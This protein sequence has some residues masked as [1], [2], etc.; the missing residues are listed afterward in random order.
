M[1]RRIVPALVALSLALVACPSKGPAAKTSG[2]RLSFPRGGLVHA[3]ILSDSIGQEGPGDPM[4]DP[5]REYGA[6]VFEIFRCCLLRTLYQ[7]SGKPTA[8]GGSQVRPDLATGP[9]EVSTDGLRWTIHIKRGLHYSPPLQKQEIVAQD[10][11]TALKRVAKVTPQDDGDY[12]VYYSVIRGFDAYAKGSADSISGIATPDP[13]TLVVTLTARAGDFADRLILAAMAPIP[14]LASAPGEFGVATG[15]DSGYGRFMI[16]TGPYMYEGSEALTP[17]APPKDEKP[18]AGFRP[19]SKAIVLVRNPSWKPATD[20]LRPA[21][22]DRIEIKLASS[23]EEIQTGI[24]RGSVD[25]RMIDGPPVQ[26]PLDQYNRYKAAP[27]LGRTYVFPRD[28]NRYV[29]MNL[30]VPPFDDVHV[31]KA[32]NYVVDRSAYINSL[33]GP[34]VGA[35][36]THVVLDSLEDNQLVNYDPYRTSGRADALAKAKAEMRLSKYDRNGDGI[37]DADACRAIDGRSFGFP[38][39]AAAAESVARD[40]ARIG[41]EVK[42]THMDGEAFFRVITDPKTRIAIGI[43]PA[44]SHDFLNA[45]NFIT[46]LFSSSRVSS[47]FTVPGGSPGNCCNYALV[48]AS[49]ADLRRWGY[50]I[51]HV[52]SADDRINECLRLIGRPQ[53]E[54]W[55]ALDQYLTEVVV[56]WVPLMIENQ[57]MTVPARVVNISFDQFTGLASLDQVVVRRSASPSPSPSS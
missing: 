57:I 26:V 12:A 47:A 3:A 19:G 48:G 11:V 42:L 29:T 27:S 39:F 9:P 4:L 18:V 37:C 20:D 50:S 44:W 32:A 53:L 36:S 5:S 13:H 56:P 1:N 14:T 45:S 8:D 2:A 54:C 40:L 46:P 15:H 51:T 52:P 21:Y 35:V 28:S 24:D 41:V 55:T 38:V 33:G 17:G 23:I 10:F 7:Y 34:V 30:A 31:R 25:V 22:P 43:A 16:A 49:S 6:E